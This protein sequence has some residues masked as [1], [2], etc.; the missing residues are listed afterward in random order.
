MLRVRT[1]V[2]KV[3]TEI[4][5]A[6]PISSTRAKSLAQADR[7]RIIEGFERDLVQPEATDNIP[8]GSIPIRSGRRRG[9]P[10]CR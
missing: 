1:V 9:V 6:R 5:I 2:A 3:E 4:E 10:I 8:I 7:R